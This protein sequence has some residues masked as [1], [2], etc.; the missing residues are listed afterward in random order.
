MC[1]LDEPGT[2]CIRPEVVHLHPRCRETSNEAPGRAARPEVQDAAPP[3]VLL[4]SRGHLPRPR[5]DSY[6]D[7]SLVHCLVLC[8]ALCYKTWF[9]V[10]GEIRNKQPSPRRVFEEV[11]EVP[12][13]RSGRRLSGGQIRRFGGPPDSVRFPINKRIKSE[14]FGVPGGPGPIWAVLGP[15]RGSPWTGRFRRPNDGRR[16]HERT[17]A[18]RASRS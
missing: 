2:R 16:D 13:G 3:V 9:T 6:Q 1:R 10:R 8:E 7:S 17:Y 11:R 18:R 14:H 4:L 5:Q 12:F 15:V